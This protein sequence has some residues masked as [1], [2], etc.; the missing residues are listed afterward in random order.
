MI[1]L[2]LLDKEELSFL[3]LHGPL[4]FGMIDGLD[5]LAIQEFYQC[6]CPIQVLQ[7]F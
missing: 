3:V 5:H 2:I 7:I 1:W 6:H 4:D